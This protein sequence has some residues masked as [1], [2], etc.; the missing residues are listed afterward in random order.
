MFLGAPKSDFFDQTSQITVAMSVAYLV[1]AKE[2]AVVK[3]R[4]ASKQGDVNKPTMAPA[5]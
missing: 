2:R 4:D 1:N 5:C 3:S